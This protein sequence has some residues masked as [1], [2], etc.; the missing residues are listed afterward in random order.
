LYGTLFLIIVV[1]VVAVIFGIQNNL[2]ITV[3]FM[4]WSFKCSEA[5]VIVVSIL[6]GLLLGFLFSFPMIHRRSKKI[7]G[8][9]NDLKGSTNSFKYEEKSKKDT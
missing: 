2:P 1:A 7:K 4:F 9:S 8:L 5:M 3:N 6:L